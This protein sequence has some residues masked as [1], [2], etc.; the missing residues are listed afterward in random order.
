MP[1]QASLR[2]G[3]KRFNVAAADLDECRWVGGQGPRPGVADAGRNAE[4]LCSPRTRSRGSLSSMP[5][6]DVPGPDVRP[7]GGAEAPTE[8]PGAR[9]GSCFELELEGAGALRPRASLGRLPLRP[10]KPAVLRVRPSGSARSPGDSLVMRILWAP[11][12][13]SQEPWGSWGTEA[14]PGVCT[15][16]RRCGHV[17]V[18]GSSQSPASFAPVL[19]LGT[20]W[21][22]FSPLTPVCG[23]VSSTASQL[24]DADPRAKGPCPR[25]P[26]QTP[27]A[28][29]AAGVHLLERP[30]DSGK[31][32]TAV[33]G[34][35]QT[36]AHVGTGRGK[37]GPGGGSLCP[38]GA[39]PSPHLHE[40]T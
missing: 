17:G 16:D 20:R 26:L 28:A 29:G 37:R 24:S 19:S 15:S 32:S 36:G 31:H 30:Q 38:L 2:A 1:A 8:A 7:A 9:H 10:C 18:L 27:V 5:G 40:L 3:Q 6:P 33:T 23:V 39:P 11:A 35:S 4:S 21:E 14:K 22:L 12:R 34:I 25:T 13:R